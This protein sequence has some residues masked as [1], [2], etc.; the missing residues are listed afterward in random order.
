MVLLASTYDQSR[1]FK[2]QDL[3]AEKKLKI[4]SVTEEE[5]GIGKDKERK[6]VVWFTNDARGLPLNL[7]NNR[8]LRGAFGDAC[9]G[10]AGK[11]IILFPTIAEFRGTMKPALR[12]R[13]PPP[14]TG[15]GHQTASPAGPVP[16]A[17]TA[18][19]VD[20]IDPELN[21]ELDF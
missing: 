15:N 8:T 11:I 6:L 21:D 16:P 20:E 18:P 17:P 10:W 13:I 14:K 2:A 3:S 1:Y 5:L 7:T 9:D 19:V 4:K 12:V